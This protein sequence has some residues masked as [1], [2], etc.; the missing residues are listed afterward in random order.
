MARLCFYID[1]FNVYHALNEK[2]V[3]G[4][5]GQFPYV[6]YKWLNY[7]AL[8]EK[9]TGRKDVISGI[10]YFT[11]Y[12]DWKPQAVNRHKEY[13]KVLR[14]VDVE[15]IRGRF[16]KKQVQCHLCKRYYTTHEEKQTDINIALKLLCD[17]IDDLYDK[18]VIISADSDLLP[19]IHAIRKHTPAKQVGVMLPIGRTSFELRKECDFRFKMSKKLLAETQFTDKVKVGKDIIERPPGWI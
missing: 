10:F 4:E 11:T 3:Q 12:V 2:R 9:F 1:G 8:A 17:A 7:R 5:V 19:A 16:M 13:I 14:N 15:V 18:A 6:K